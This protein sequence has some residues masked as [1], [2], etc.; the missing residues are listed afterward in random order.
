M[1]LGKTSTNI[2][3]K[4]EP[5]ELILELVSFSG[6]EDTV[7][8][9]QGVKSNEG[10]VIQNWDSIFLGGMIR[11]PGFTSVADQTASYTNK[12]ID[13]MLHHYE[14]T[15]VRNYAIVNGDLTRINGTALTVTDSASFTAGVLTHGLTAGS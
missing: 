11:S 14:G 1:P 7:E 5:L 10:R 9:D 12:A 13:C 4:T 6:G 15:T 2:L 3:N 8:E